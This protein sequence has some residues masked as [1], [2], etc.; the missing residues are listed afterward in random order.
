M[1]HVRPEVV[2]PHGRPSAEVLRGQ[3]SLSPVQ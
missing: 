1:R 2:L 3:T